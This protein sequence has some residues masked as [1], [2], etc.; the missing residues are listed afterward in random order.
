[1]ELRGLGVFGG[2]GFA[3]L[4]LLGPLFSRGSALRSV[5]TGGQACVEEQNYCAHTLV[6]PPLCLTEQPFP[7]W[8]LEPS[9]FIH[10]RG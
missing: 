9:G 5:S 1:M 6:T 8:S 7:K 2:T 10:F 3:S 4:V